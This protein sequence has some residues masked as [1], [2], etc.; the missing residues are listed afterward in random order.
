MSPTVYALTL[1]SVLL[2]MAALWFYIRLRQAGV[3]LADSATV[4]SQ[5]NDVLESVLEGLGDCC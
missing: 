4:L 1:T 2:G 3:P 5:R